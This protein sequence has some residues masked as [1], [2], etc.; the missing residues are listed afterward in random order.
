MLEFHLSTIIFTIINLLVLY[1]VLRKVLFG[2][3][4]D[5]LEQRAQLVQQEIDA[6]QAGNR[7]AQEL[8]AQ[9]EGQ[10]Q[11][12]HQEAAKIVADAQ[13]RAQR[14]YDGTVAEAQSEAQRL[15]HEAQ[16][17][18]ASERETMLRSAR[19]EVASLALLAAAKA[20]GRS[21]DGNDD[22]AFVDEFLLEVG[23]Q[24]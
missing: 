21:M 11:D 9:Y 17:Q 3:V 10:L 14:V 2:K 5:V 19:Q 23:E 8:K 6:A 16:A 18:I 4:N 7:Q 12:A 24:A 20:A 13:T 15:R 22:K 1:A